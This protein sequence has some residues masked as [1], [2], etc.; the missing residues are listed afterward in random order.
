MAVDALDRLLKL[1][2]VAR[3]AVM[4]QLSQPERLTLLGAIEFR[5]NNP[6]I[7]YQGDP[8]GFVQDGLGETIW[9]KQVE[10][11]ESLRDNKRTAVSACHAPGKTHLAARIVAYWATVYPPGTTKIITTST[12]YR[13]VKN[14]LWPHIR[15][16]Q[17]DKGLPGWTN[18]TEW[19][20][21]DLGEL[22]AEGI[23]PPDHQE[24]ALNGYHA[25]N[26]LIL[27]DEAG[28]ISP[29]FGRDLEALTT[30]V[31][32][33]M[34]ILGN[35]PVDAERT[36]FEGICGSPNYNHIEISA[37]DTP[38]FTKE[39]TDMCAS[40]P[41]GVPP[42]EIAQHLVDELWVANLAA[43]FGTDSAF[44][45]ARALAKF[46]RDNASKT[47]PMSWLE[48]AHENELETGTDRIMLGVDIA[49]DGG[50]EFVIAK[51]DGWKLTIEYSKSG[52]DNESSVDVAGKILEHIREAERVHEQR[53]ITEPVRVKIDSIGV[54]WGVVGL[55]KQ[56]RKENKMQ[57]EIVGVNVA[58]RARDAVKFSSQR[59]EMWWNFRQLIQPDPKNDGDP[60]LHIATSLKEMAQLNAPT[61]KTDS[62]GRI[63]I[64]SKQAMKKRGVNSP[65]RAEAMLL[66]VYEP[67]VK[68]TIVA[69]VGLGGAN[70]WDALRR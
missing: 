6:W 69:P 70:P 22:V 36:W 18:P 55:L 48:A 45:K 17:R 65:D 7:K 34:V 46:P 63:Q 50:D 64:E 32:T 38:N 30:G 40:C 52:A 49:S 51:A 4:T 12:T 39:K 27:V 53:G 57:A 43:E 60:V 23:K 5:A 24:A 14:A 44:Y 25:P 54:G 56:W 33:K 16:I 42:H 19:K 67:V 62:A 20:I 1:D 58:E 37:F 31:N 3:R 35:P 13:Q 9:S 21:G 28:G 41:E 29:S 11:L 8:V 59:S 66:C 61:Y 26:M 10:I 68:K 47:L 2:P 15:R